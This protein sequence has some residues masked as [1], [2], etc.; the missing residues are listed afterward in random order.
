[1]E[2]SITNAEAAT[3]INP[4]E[5]RL[6]LSLLLSDLNKETDQR[7]KKISKNYKIFLLYITFYE[8][9]LVH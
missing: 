3:P 7:L 1:M 9:I 4:L 8:K 5:R 2:T 6:D